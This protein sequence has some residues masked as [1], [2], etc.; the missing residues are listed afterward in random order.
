MEGDPVELDWLMVADELYAADTACCRLMQVDPRNIL[1]LRHRER[2]EAFHEHEEITYNQDWKPFVREKFYLA[3]KWTD[4]PGLI[5]FHSR[6]WAYVAYH[7]PLSSLLHKLLYMF[8]KPLYDYKVPEN[9][10]S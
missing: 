10:K 5:A 1:Y 3:R 6:F 9:T 4:Y 2:E 8:R 7:S